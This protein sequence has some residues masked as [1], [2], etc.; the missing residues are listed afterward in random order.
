M[1]WVGR[2]L[3]DHQVPTPA[4][5]RAATHQLRLLRAPS[6]LQGWGTKALRLACA[7]LLSSQ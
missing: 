4:V 3:K 2:D 1:A 7:A 5:G 6:S